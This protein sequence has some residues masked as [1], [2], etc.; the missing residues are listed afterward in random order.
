MT[1]KNT[2]CL[3]YDGTAL[4][5]SKFYAG[6][7][8]DSA[9]G[10]V[11]RAPGDYPAGKARDA[12]TVLRWVLVSC[13]LLLCGAAQSQ[14]LF[15]TGFEPPA[16]AVGP[17]GVQDGWSSQS[18][19]SVQSTTKF[20]G[21]QALQFNPTGLAGGFFTGHGVTYSS[22]GNPARL[23][24][25]TTNFQESL[26]GV[27]T[28]WTVLSG[29]SATAFLC[30]VFVAGGNFQLGL[31][32]SAVGSIPIV[33]GQWQRAQLDFNFATKTCSAF[34]DGA[35]LGSGSFPN[36]ADFARLEVG[37]NSSP[38][39]DR[40]F[41]DDIAIEATPFVDNGDGTVTDASTGLMWDQCARGRS[42]V[43]CATGAATLYPWANAFA[44]AGT[45]SA[46][47]YKGYSDW[48]LPS[49]VE[50]QTLVKL[51][52]SPTVDATAFP[53]TPAFLW[54]GSSI[55][56]GATD[57]W[58]VSFNDGT[59][60]VNF[61]TDGLYVRLVRAGQY[62]GSFALVPGGVSGITKTAA[63][64]PATSPVGATGRW[65]IVPRDATPPTPAQVIAGVSYGGV[66]VVA[67]NGAMVA[68]TLKTFA[69]TALTT[70][71]AYDLYLVA[72]DSRT[73]FPS[74][75]V[76]PLQFSTL[77]PYNTFDVD[78]NTQVDALTDGLI[79]LRYMLGLRAPALT[80]GAVGPGA[81]RDAA[82]IETHT[83]SAM[84]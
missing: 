37:I 33:R 19:A 22:V 64:L 41:W 60:Y 26:T 31:Q 58:Y 47:N 81:T 15:Q 45:Q 59:A 43:G 61:R 52:A 67:G 30:Q 20:A 4:D 24:R 71:T 53:N 70:G 72:T 13:V 18:A 66:T 12:L 48:R 21:A 16:Y 46:N 3:R 76:G 62:F 57:A 11:Y 23:V 75:L 82:A 80:A 27:P 14:V 40:A 7:F 10:A 73:V 8:P 69:I 78:G 65:M 1:S 63:V 83:R 36:V 17:L 25:I 54:S 68:N 6:T 28:T 34:V 35:F 49:A 79:L 32:S 84:P 29:R 42:G 51:G 2:I 5:A 9:V 44:E 38:G 77:G 56:G 50:L 74:Q 55:A 39:T